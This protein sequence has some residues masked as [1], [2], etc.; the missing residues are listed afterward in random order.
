LLSTTAL[1]VLQWTVG[2]AGGASGRGVTCPV[3]ADGELVVDSATRRQRQTAVSAVSAPTRRTTPAIENTVQVRQS[4][5]HLP[6]YDVFTC[7]TAPPPCFGAILAPRYQI[8]LLAY[9]WCVLI[10]HLISPRL[11]S[12]QLTAFHY[13]YEVCALRL[14]AATVKWVVRPIAM[15]SLQ[16]KPKNGRTWRVTARRSSATPYRIVLKNRM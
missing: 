6:R 8:Y 11:T 2:G 15:H 1:L 5:S 16:M 10:T 3:A 4:Q 12:S 9:L 13:I 7:R 14:V